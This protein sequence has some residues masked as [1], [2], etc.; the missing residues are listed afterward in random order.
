VEAFLAPIGAEAMYISL[1]LTLSTAD[2]KRI[3]IRVV[4]FL[5]AFSVY[6]ATKR[7]SAVAFPA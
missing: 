5:A 4:N 6:V 1:T 2:M 3:D 7:L